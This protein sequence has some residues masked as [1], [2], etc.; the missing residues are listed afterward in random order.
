[1]AN[2]VAEL[3]RN[4]YCYCSIGVI[5]GL[6]GVVATAEVAGESPSAEDQRPEGACGC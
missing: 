6:V 2:L 5:W 4:C 1:M 3:Y